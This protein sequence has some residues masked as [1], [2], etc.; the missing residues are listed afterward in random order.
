[1]KF[2][3]SVEVFKGRINIP[4]IPGVCQGIFYNSGNAYCC[5]LV[6]KNLVVIADGKYRNKRY[7]AAAANYDDLSSSCIV[8]RCE[9]VGQTIHPEHIAT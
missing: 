2:L 3:F 4:G 1:M 8:P 6:S 7:S 9:I 5:N